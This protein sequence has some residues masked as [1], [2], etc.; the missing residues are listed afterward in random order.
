MQENTSRR[1]VL[2]SAGALVSGGIASKARAVSTPESDEG[3]PFR[4]SKIYA[5]KVK[6]LLN[7]GVAGGDG[8][9]VLAGQV[10]GAPGSVQP[11]LTSVGGDGETNWSRTLAADGQFHTKDVV[12]N[13][14]GYVVA[15]LFEPAGGEG[16]EH[17]LIGVDSSGAQQWRRTYDSSLD[18]RDVYALAPSPDGGVVFVGTATG[19]SR[20]VARVVSV[21]SGGEVEWERELDDYIV[22]YPFHVRPATDGGYLVLGAVRGSSPDRDADAPV[23][24][25]AVKL[26]ADGKTAWQREHRQR[27]TAGNSSVQVLNDAVETDEGYL[28]AGFVAPGFEAD[29][30]RGWGLS[31][32]AAGE[33]QY[34]TLARPEGGR[35]GRFRSVV[36]Y[37]GGYVLAGGGPA[38]A[39]GDGLWMLGVGPT[40]A[41]RWRYREAYGGTVRISDVVQLAD[42][43]FLVVAT[44][45]TEGNSQGF[46]IKFG[47]DPE[48]TPTPT[49]TASPTATETPTPTRTATPT[50]RTRAETAAAP[51]ETSTTSADGPGFGVGATLAALGAGAVLRYS[52]SRESE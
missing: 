18:E 4:W 29:G 5:P 52:G 7:G 2:F 9:T 16:R 10:S 15:G 41:R 38:G 28:Y 24:G 21:D 6:T 45:S 19:G 49:R 27:S 17:V 44:R 40:L 14:E 32:D 42:G 8:S 34:S 13:G 23:T 46:V 48:E 33:P 3:P 26:N 35:S 12:R 31:V 36:P 11:Y 39:A 47:G 30:A 37:D 22:N 50:V 51:A 25:W 43:G 1:S 20:L